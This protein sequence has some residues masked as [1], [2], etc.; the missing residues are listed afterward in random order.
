MGG[1]LPYTV[2]G[3]LVC[4]ASG[5]GSWTTSNLKSTYSWPDTLLFWEFQLSVWTQLFVYDNMHWRHTPWGKEGSLTISHT[6]WNCFYKK[7][8]AC[9][10]M[11]GGTSCLHLNAIPQET[12]AQGDLSGG[13]GKRSVWLRQRQRE[14]MERAHLLHLEP[15]GYFTHFKSKV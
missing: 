5:K 14:A 8:K 13:S 11:Q 9:T 4:A 7:E 1:E 2:R 6:L 12:C 10:P 15:H 3:A